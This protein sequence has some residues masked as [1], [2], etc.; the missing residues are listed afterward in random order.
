MKK[1]YLEPEFELANIILKDK[2]LFHS[3]FESG[4]ENSGWNWNDGDD[5]LPPP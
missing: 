4:G 5:D 3:E 1:P 2:I